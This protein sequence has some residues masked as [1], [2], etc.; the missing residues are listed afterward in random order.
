M[1]CSGPPNHFGRILVDV[2]A[3]IQQLVAAGGVATNSEAKALPIPPT[4]HIVFVCA[5]SDISSA[6]YPKM[7]K[8][9]AVLPPVLCV[10]GADKFGAMHVLRVRLQHAL[11]ET[12]SDLFDVDICDEASGEHYA[13]AKGGTNP[14][15]AYIALGKEDKHGELALLLS[16]HLRHVTLRAIDFKTM[17]STGSI[18]TIDVKDGSVL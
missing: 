8:L 3:M 13:W 15:C 2:P 12:L 10:D 4:A 9:A 16:R 18:V 14:R 11:R 7:K 5:A 1:S 17:G 6:L